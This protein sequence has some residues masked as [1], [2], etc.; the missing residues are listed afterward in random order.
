MSES[1]VEE[2]LPLSPLQQG[3]L[4][5]ALYDAAGTDV[6]TMQFHVSLEGELDTARFKAAAEALIDR[7]ANL[8]TGF[9]HEDLDDPVQVILKRV[10]LPWSEVDLSGLDEAVQQ[11]ELERLSEEDVVKR[12]DLTSPPLLRFTIVKLA[13]TQWLLMMSNHH[14]L[15]DGWSIPLLVRELL[16]LYGAQGELPPVRPYRNFLAWLVSRDRDVAADAWR[17]A[18]DGVVEPTLLASERAAREPVKPDIVTM[19]LT[20]ELTRSL[21]RTAGSRRLTV[22]TVVQGLWARLVGALTGQDDVVFGATVSGRPADLPDVES[23]I[24]LFINTVPVRV[25]MYPDEPLSKALRRLQDEQSKLIEFH[26]LGLAEIHRA[27]GTGHL[28]DSLVVFE[29]YPLDVD[30]VT[31][32]A[33]GTGLS[34]KKWHANGATHY[35]LTLAAFA[36][37]KFSVNFEFR[38]DVFER[39]FVE[40]LAERLRGLVEDFTADPDRQVAGMRILGEGERDW[41]LTQG[42]GAHLDRDE[43]TLPRVFEQQ[44]MYTPDAIA[45]VGEDESLTFAELNARANK[46]AHRLIEAGAGPEKIVAFALPPEPDAIVALLG[47]LKSGAAYLP[48][49]PAWPVDRIEG[50]LADAEPVALL[51]TR[52]SAPEVTGAP[53]ILLDEPLDYPAGSPDVALSP[54]HPAYVIYTSGSTGRPKAVMVPHRAIVNL[55]TSHKN[56]LFDPAGGPLRIGHAWPIVFDASWQPMLWMFAGHELHLVP[57]KTRRDPDLLRRFLAEHRI[58]FIELSPSLLGEIVTAEDWRGDLKVLAVGGEGVPPQLW[59]F[60]REQ[61][62]LVTYNLYGPTEATVDSAACAVSWSDKPS[63]G[64]P[65]ANAFMYVLDRHLNPVP[66]GVPGELYIGGAGLARGYLRRPRTTSSRFV[67]DPFAGEPGARMYRTGDIARFTPEGFVDLLGRVDDQIKIRGFRIEPGEIENALLRH[68]KVERA[69]VVVREDTPGVRRLVAYLVAPGAD[70]RQVR[71]FSSKSLPDYMVPSVCVLVDTFPLTHNGKLDISK[72]PVPELPVGSQPPR[73]A[74]EKE[75]AEV[76]AEVLGLKTV[77]VHDDFF[78][79]G[80]DSLLSMR[81]IGKVRGRGMDLSP[82]DVFERPTVAELAL[83]GG[84]R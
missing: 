9:M 68:E 82:H 19:E 57:E 62:G 55:L 78:E 56:Q 83:K 16:K 69:A 17:A 77:G 13:A 52:T 31:D 7:H 49:D 11:A 1:L 67:A 50:M 63:I 34:V 58:E 41:L 71:A 23:M 26:Y 84:S 66:A 20:E 72:L 44:A 21:H 37:R 43:R 18:L 27:A 3:F 22:N 70:P 65:V 79:L 25:R 39:P 64:R 81:L 10:D 4:F 47:V 51:T 32:A 54:E 8:R 28:F 80:G 61:E 35:P 40:A 36:E 38:P 74:A 45:V 76:F 75:L 29:N 42:I 46:L 59:K 2:V 60:L 12:F 53:V 5:H 73:T 30:A 14:L 15:L 33:A 6:Y 24:G 48:L